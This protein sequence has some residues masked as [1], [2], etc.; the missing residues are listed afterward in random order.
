MTHTAA[1]CTSEAERFHT[2][3]N[4]SHTYADFRRRVLI[5]GKRKTQYGLQ[6][7]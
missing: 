4:D 5:R 3:Q 7:E 2:N 1:P 6:G